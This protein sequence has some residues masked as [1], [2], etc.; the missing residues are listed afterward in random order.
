EEVWRADPEALVAARDLWSSLHRHGLWHQRHGTAEEALRFHRRALEVLDGTREDHTH[1][2][3]IRQEKLSSLR[4]LEALHAHR[5]EEE[6]ARACRER[7][8][9]IG[10]GA[11]AK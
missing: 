3:L 1:R 5:G 4:E 11:V 8:E 6:E 10:T 7:A 9:A 2:E